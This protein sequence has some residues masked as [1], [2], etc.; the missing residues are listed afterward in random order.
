MFFMN[1]EKKFEKRLLAYGADFSRWSVAEAAQGRALME[2]SEAARRLFDEAKKLDAALDMF[3]VPELEA[4][5]VYYAEMARQKAAGLRTPAP[6]KQ[7]RL[8]GSGWNG[9][10]PAGGFAAAACLLLVL[11]GPH[12]GKPGASREDLAV[13]AEAEQNTADQVIAMMSDTGE[14]D[15]FLDDLYDGGAQP[16]AP[17]Q[18]PDIWNYFMDSGQG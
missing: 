6:K 18:Q 9:W 16:A 17:A 5:P 11:A 10:A 2:R 14:V 7:A 8:F 15:D 1:E 3:A 4:R 13:V 12:G